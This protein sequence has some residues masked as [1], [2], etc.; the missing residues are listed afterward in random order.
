VL[1]DPAPVT[2]LGDELVADLDWITPNVLETEVL[3]GIAP[4][5]E[6][7]A[8]RSGRMLLDRGVD[9]VAITLGAEGCFY[10]GAEGSFFVA[11][12]SVPVV[13]TVAAGDAFVGALA[14]ALVKDADVGT[15][16]ERACAAGA[17]ATTKAGA[18]PSLP[19][20]AE[21]DALLARSA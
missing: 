20:G 18:Q 21:V 16:L 7:D 2:T 1:L 14:A 19:T 15:A 13:D 10:T 17:L 3:T 6:A 11:A 9:H 4:L 8:R 5:T 12:P